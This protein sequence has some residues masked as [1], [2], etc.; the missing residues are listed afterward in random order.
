MSSA[1]HSQ[2]SVCHADPNL[3]SDVDSGATQI[4]V[5]SSVTGRYTLGDEIARGDMGIIYRATDTVLGR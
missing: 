2:R 1:D 4:V 5:P 3:T